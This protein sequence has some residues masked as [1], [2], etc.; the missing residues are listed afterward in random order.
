[1]GLKESGL[2]ASVRSVSTVV[3]AF[4]DV[5]IT[6]TNS[7]VNE[8]DVLVVDYSVD[9]TGDSFET[10]DIRL[11]IESVQEDADLD[12]SLSGGASDSGTLE[13][14]TTGQDADTYEA[15]VLSDDDSDT[16]TVEIPDAFF[17]VAIQ[18]T[19][20][21]VEEGE[22][23]NVDYLVDNTGGVEDT[24]D[25]RLEIDNTQEDVDTDVTLD[26][27]TS[28]TGTL[29]W[30]TTDESAD[31]YSAT[32]L[33]DDDSDSVT[34]EI[35]SAIPDSGGT[36]QWNHDEGSDTTLGD[37]I[38]SL[39]GSING[40]SWQSGA[41]TKDTHLDYNGDDDHTDLGSQSRVAFKHFTSDKQ[42]TLFCWINPSN[43]S[44]LSAFWGATAANDNIGFGF[45]LN[46]DD[47]NF[48][49][50]DGSGTP[51]VSM[52]ATNVASTGWQ[53]VAVTCDGSDARIWHGESITEEATESIGGGTTDDFTHNVSF[54]R[55]TQ[56]GGIQYYDGKIDLA[57]SDDVARS[58][59][60]LQSFVDDTKQ[61][62]E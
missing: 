28:T 4:F 2:R 55:I 52:G 17:D 6:D 1:M 45:R 15:T 37:V 14:D 18:S 29:Q 35:E 38:G 11:E 16:V 20:S 7:P 41:G 13:W 5:A 3:P 49:M 32:V 59:S 54:G 62:Y 30:D 50:N 47:I 36:H 10:Q 8:G 34:V 33:S 46:D 51:M 24:Q 25:I 21:P 26:S 39:D 61:F 12:V 58:Q 22:T 31:T 23:L 27:D 48:F 43:V 44:G 42:G 40:A 56:D 57:W 60:E 53:P 9:N 19:N